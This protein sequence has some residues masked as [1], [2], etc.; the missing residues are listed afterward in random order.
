MSKEI[1][2][3][4]YIPAT[5]NK[6]QLKKLD[7]TAKDFYNICSQNDQ[8]PITAIQRSSAMGLLRQLL[9][10][11][12][13]APVMEL[14]GSALGFKTDKDK[15]KV[16]GKYVKGRG[17]PVEVVRD[18][19]IFALGK[20][21][22]MINNEVNIIAENPYLT[23]NYFFRSLDEKLGADGWIITH[24]VPEVI[25]TTEQNGYGKDVLKVK[26]NVVSNVWWKDDKTGATGKTQKLVFS[27]KGDSFATS[28]SYTGKADRKAANW[29][30][31]N[32][33]GQRFIDAD[34]DE[35]FI[36]VTPKSEVTDVKPAINKEIKFSDQLI[37]LDINPTLLFEQM[38]NE[39]ME[40]KSQFNYSSVDDFTPP[41]KQW[42]LDHINK[43]DN[44][45]SL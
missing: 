32:I 6:E 42:I 4:N 8:S 2:K 14:Q 43:F 7:D 16:N 15:E 45:K 34:V 28:D 21:A 30:L 1:T 35:D 10:P 17:Y 13:M 19:F 33:T 3:T 36:D 22:Q 40:K 26:A 39:A 44:C 9:T 38:K 27:I 31:S 11:E 25:K 24:E 37:G 41:L 5:V 20:G 18:T 12:I 23:K 29:L